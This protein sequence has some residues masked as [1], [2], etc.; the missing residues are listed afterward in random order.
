MH[1]DSE[2]MGRK[3]MNIVTEPIKASMPIHVKIAMSHSKVI[4]YNMDE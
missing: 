3:K 1:E 4:K 2:R